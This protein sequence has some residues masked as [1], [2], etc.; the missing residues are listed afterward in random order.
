MGPFTPTPEPFRKKC[1]EHILE[2]VLENGENEFTPE[3]E[4]VTKK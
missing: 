3:N 1:F 4:Q 2:A